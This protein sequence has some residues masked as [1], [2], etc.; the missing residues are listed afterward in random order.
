[1]KIDQALL[2]KVE[3]RF[4]QQNALKAALGGAFWSIPALVIWY[5]LYKINGNMGPIMLLLNGVVIGAAV[6]WHGKGISP[7][8]SLLAFAI[9]FIV[10]LGAL[11][12]GIGVGSTIGAIYLFG[13]FAIGGFAAIYIARIR[14]PFHEHKAYFH[15]TEFEPSPNLKKLK[16]RW[17]TALPLLLVL[18]P[19]ASAIAIVGIMTYDNVLSL[20]ELVDAEE[21]AYQKKESKNIDISPHSLQHM[22]TRDIFLYAHAYYTG[23]RHNYKGYVLES[24]PRSEFKAKTILNYLMEERENNRARFVLGLISKNHQG[25]ALIE[26][27]AE[28][29]DKY[30]KLYSLI[31]FGCTSN[32]TQAQ[33]LLQSYHNQTRDTEFKEEIGAVTSLGFPQVCYDLEE[34]VFYLSYALEG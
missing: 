30:A 6:R 26:E 19:L 27:A 14:V 18:T 17:F 7:L 8:F 4:S 13:L 9:H 10:C 25:M 29:G 2:D 31:N 5:S 34:P 24:F 11:A 12:T 21:K 22:E 20:S 33:T 23:K 15:L 3:T 28:Q 32:P 1:M 16:N